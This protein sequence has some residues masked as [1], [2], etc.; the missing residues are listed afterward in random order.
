MQSIRVLRR[1][2]S[3][4]PALRASTELGVRPQAMNL[5]NRQILLGLVAVA[6][7]DPA[8][9]SGDMTVILFLAAQLLLV[10]VFLFCLSAWRNWKE[11]AA[12][13]VFFFAPLCMVW[14]FTAE[15]AYSENRG[16]LALLH[17]GGPVAGWAFGSFVVHAR[18]DRAAA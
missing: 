6:S 11:R 15:T 2:C 14:L 5:R 3:I 4:T 12:I 17:L 10:G 1:R 8:M 9:A 18:R 16:W 13:A 7:A